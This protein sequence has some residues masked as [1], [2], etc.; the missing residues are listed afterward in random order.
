M[1]TKREDIEEKKSKRLL[2]RIKK[3]IGI[4]KIPVKLGEDLKVELTHLP[5]EY[6]VERAYIFMQMISLADIPDAKDKGKLDDKVK[7]ETGQKILGSLGKDEL[8]MIKELLEASLGISYPDWP[9]EEIKN[10]IGRYFMEFMIQGMELFVPNISASSEGLD[11]LSKAQK[12]AKEFR[13]EQESTKE[14]K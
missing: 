11:K 5:P 1:A 6:A 7:Q 3:R 13:E 12:L 2:N 14:S 8:K 10:I 4:D 9:E